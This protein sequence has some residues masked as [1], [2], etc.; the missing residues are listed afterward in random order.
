MITSV[1]FDFT[2]HRHEPAHF[3]VPMD[4]RTALGLGIDGPVHLEIWTASGHVR[5][6]FLMA[7][8]GEVRASAKPDGPNRELLGVVPA[9]S[10]GVAVASR[11]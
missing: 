7:S 5:G 4:V 1:T 9:G 3:T 6:K 11:P 8:N 10:W 2:S